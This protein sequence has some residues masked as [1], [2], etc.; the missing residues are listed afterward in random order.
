MLT[1]DSAESRSFCSPAPHTLI[2][3]IAS[4]VKHLSPFEFYYPADC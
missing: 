1:S 4:R 2:V 3:Q